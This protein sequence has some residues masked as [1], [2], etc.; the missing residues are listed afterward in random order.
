M[1]DPASIDPSI[2]GVALSLGA[3][4]GDAALFD[5][6][7][8]R[9]ENA[10][11]PADRS[12][13]LQAIGSFQDPALRDRALNYALTGPMRPNEIFTIPFT[14]GDSPGGEDVVF[15]WT[16]ANF[17]AITKR[18]PPF[19]V[20]FMPYSAGGC[21]A[22]RLAKAQDF[23]A[24]PAHQGTGTETTMQKVTDQVTDCV[25]LREREGEKVAAYLRTAATGTTAGAGA[26]S[27]AGAGAR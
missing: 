2:A 3:K 21:S 16:V 17:D 15:A 22:E 19:V 9:F 8:Q 10:Q 18:M 24:D 23:F 25:R 12:R 7:V 6:L 11:T 26:S 4:K 14:I 27:G 5:E 20:G 1:A 13:Y